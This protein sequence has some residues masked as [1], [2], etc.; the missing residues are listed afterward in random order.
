MR[1]RP[2][3]S[4]SL[5]ALI[6]ILSIAAAGSAGAQSGTLTI[7]PSY[8]VPLGSSTE[9]FA[10]G[11]GASL[12]ATLPTGLSAMPDA[13]TAA[14]EIAVENAVLAVGTESVPGEGNKTSREP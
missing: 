5:A 3:P 10:A 6:A 9:L 12:D 13:V 8:A 1:P 7:E 11:V 4:P 14:T 2:N